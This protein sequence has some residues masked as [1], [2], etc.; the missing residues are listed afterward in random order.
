MVHRC[1]TRFCGCFCDRTANLLT[2]SSPGFNPTFTKCEY[3]I[4]QSLIK[5]T[6]FLTEM[7]RNAHKK[8]STPIYRGRSHGD[9]R[10]DKDARSRIYAAS[11]E[12]WILN[13]PA[14]MRYHSP[15]KH[16]SNKRKTVEI[17]VCIAPEIK[18]ELDR[19]CTQGAG[20][21]EQLS[22]S[23]VASQFIAQGVRGHIDMQY[24]AL[25]E[26]VI[27]RAIDNRLK[28]AVARFA[29]L[30]VRIAYDSGQ[31]RALLTN[32]LARS[33]G[34]T[35]ELLNA[36]VDQSGRRA[37]ANLTHFSPQIAELIQ[38]VETW[39]IDTDKAGTAPAP[40]EG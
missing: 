25:L 10:Q 29:A 2:Y 18:A 32:L 6:D 31:S 38:A 5:Q 16:G 26:P 24:G 7:D 11:G 37:K 1:S 39:M 3:A 22:I 17:G 4:L 19:L 13:E 33:P 40:T 35:P 8:Q 20:N 27:E 30:L 9:V 28:A 34:V 23:K 36:I 14:N 15:K 21:G 12:P